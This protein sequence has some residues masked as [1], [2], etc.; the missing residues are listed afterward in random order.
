MIAFRTL[1]P[2][3][4]ARARRS[5]LPTDAGSPPASGLAAKLKAGA[6][7]AF[8]DVSESAERMAARMIDI[9]ALTGACTDADLIEAGF[10]PDDLTRDGRIARQ[11]AYGVSERRVA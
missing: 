6:D 7:K 11:L 5:N 1:T 3:E 4:I 2:A 9:A 10:T 8:P